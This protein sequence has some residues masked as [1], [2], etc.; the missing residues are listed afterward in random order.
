MGEGQ[1]KRQ[2]NKAEAKHEKF[3]TM[4]SS[5][6]SR[7]LAKRAWSIQNFLARGRSSERLAGLISTSGLPGSGAFVMDRIFLSKLPV[8]ERGPAAVDDVPSSARRWYMPARFPLGIE[9][10][11]L[12][13]PSH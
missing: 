5:L 2:R 8:D 10:S 9:A 3:F 4:A 6:S 13:P 7:I 1:R 11:P 12:T